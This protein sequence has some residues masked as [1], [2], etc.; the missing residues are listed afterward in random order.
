MN[1]NVAD[2]TTTAIYDDCGNPVQNALVDGTFSGDFSESFYDVA[3]DENGVAVFTTAGCIKKPSFSF[4]VDAV[5]DTLP[6]DP[7]DDFAT[8]CSG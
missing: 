7:G 5:T 2:Q 8:G 3:T 4:T 6:H 1:K